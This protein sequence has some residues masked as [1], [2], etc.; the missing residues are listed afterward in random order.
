VSRRI[1]IAATISRQLLLDG[2]HVFSTGWHEHDAEQSWGA[3]ANG[4]DATVDFI[5]DG[6][7]DVD[8]RFH[9]VESDLADATV[10]DRLVRDTVERYGSIDIVIACHARSAS[11]SLS[12]LTVDELDKCWTVNARSTVLLAQ[13]LLKHRG[14]A[15]GGGRLISFSSGQHLGGMPNELPY[16]I[17]KGAIQQM[18]A[19]L[20]DVMI[21]AGITVNCINP[22]RRSR[23]ARVGS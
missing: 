12:E 7:A 9:Y 1:G 3:E 10:P 22:G 8:Q 4:P 20:S 2:A 5:T 11:Q 18:T 21:D 17:S 15:R 6:L 13:A 16:A 19:S 23:S 14:A